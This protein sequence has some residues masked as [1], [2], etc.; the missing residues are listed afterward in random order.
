[1]GIYLN[2]DGEAFEI[3]VQSDIYVDKTNMLSYLNSVLGKEQRFVCVSR[4]RR[5]GKSIAANM[6][7]AYYSRASDAEKIFRG[8]AI[9]K[10]GSFRRYAGKY[11]VIHL[12]MQDFLSNAATMG[13]MLALLQKS[14]LWDLLKEYP[15][16]DYFDKTNFMRTM[17]DVY[18]N[19]KRRFVIVID[20]WDCIFREYREHQDWQNQYLDFLRTWLKD[21]VYIEL[22]YMTGILPI[23]KY[24]T[25]SALNMFNEFSM[26]NPGKLAEYVGFIGSE[27]EGLCQRYGIRYEEC[28]AWYD[29]YSFP[30]Q[31]VQ[32]VYNPR[33]VISVMLNGTFDNYWNKTETF[34]ALKIYIDLNFDGLKE[35]IIALMSGERKRINTKNFAN[36]MSTFHDKDDVLTLLIHLGYLG[37]DFAASSVFIPN[38]EIL[39]EYANSVRSGDWSNVAEAVKVSEELLDSTLNME[40]EKVAHGIEAAHLET[41]HLTYNDENALAY[42]ISLAYYTARQKY[43]VVREFPTGKGFA[44]LVYLPRPTHPELPAMLIELKWNKEAK[45]AIRQIKEKQYV[46][47]LKDYEGR[48]LLIGISYD[49]STRKHECEIEEWER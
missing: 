29:G 38:Q 40:P 8:L 47:A 17:S 28:K 30:A 33:S 42:T 31:G 39:A 32:E 13:D 37:Y 4:P 25:H 19:T 5:F 49:K 6:V 41:S 7:S 3:A 43:L 15:D 11:D 44:D 27:V 23:K 21:K 9:E 14:I 10:A 16:Y 24:G 1:M 26:E 2:P 12:N 20:E 18:Q 45:T 46:H 36:D 22:A 35:A 48:I 34:E